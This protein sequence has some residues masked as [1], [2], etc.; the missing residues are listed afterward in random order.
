MSDVK[1]ELAV[2]MGWDKRAAAKAA[3]KRTSKMSNRQIVND[4]SSGAPF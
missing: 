1:S 4:N 3:L 2:A